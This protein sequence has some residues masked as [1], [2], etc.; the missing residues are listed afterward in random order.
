LCLRRSCC[1]GRVTVE[2][3]WQYDGKPAA[4]AEFALHRNGAAHLLDKLL[5]DRHAESGTHIA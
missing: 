5:H 4:F 3:K 2:F 1:C